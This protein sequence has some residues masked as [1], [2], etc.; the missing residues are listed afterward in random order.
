MPGKKILILVL[1]VLALLCT[2]FFYANRNSK[3]LTV[4]QKLLKAVYPLLVLFNSKKHIIPP[5]KDKT[6]KAPVYIYSYIITLN[7]G[8]DLSL[9]NFKGKKM[10]FVNTASNCGYTHQYAMLEKIA[11]EYKN[12]LAMI[13]F[14]ANDF[15]QQEPDDDASIAQFCSLNYGISFPIAKKSSVVKGTHQNPVFQ[16]LSNPGLN[17]WNNKGPDWNFCKY[18]IDEQGNL[19]AVFPSAI[20]PDAAEV[21]NAINQ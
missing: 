18:L 20:T 11:E 9:S 7:N 4:R 14:P 19:M 3:H 21:I 10:M 1:V 16:W 13:A 6:V 15:K 5:G 17:G 8:A 2:W 12:K